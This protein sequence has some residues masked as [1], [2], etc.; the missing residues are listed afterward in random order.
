MSFN[1]EEY[2]KFAQQLVQEAQGNSQN[3]LA[4]EVAY[5]NAISRAYYSAFNKAR[6]Y[7]L[8]TTIYNPSR[9]D[10][11]TH[12]ILAYSNSIFRERKA[13]APKLSRMKDMRVRAD[14]FGNFYDPT[15]S[16]VRE[17]LPEIAKKTVAEARDVL[18]M[19][20]NFKPTTVRDI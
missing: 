14:Y 1:W 19:I 11:H 4:N 7:L 12:L 2:L 17:P 3:P 16:R 15:I 6:E 9:G 8:T 13:L 10:S 5:R 18:T 20:I